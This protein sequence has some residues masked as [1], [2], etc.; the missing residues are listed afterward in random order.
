MVRCK[1]CNVSACII[2]DDCFNVVASIQRQ[3]YR[4]AQRKNIR[5]ASYYACESTIR[6]VVTIYANEKA[7]K[8]NFSWW[9][10]H[11]R[12]GNVVDTSYWCCQSCV[13]RRCPHSGVPRLLLRK[14]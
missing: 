11:Q 14:F 9:V 7:T 3:K 10:Y 6:C 1:A 5:S 12:R 2:V 4:S 8:L 13:V